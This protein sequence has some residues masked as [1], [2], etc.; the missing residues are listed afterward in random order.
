VYFLFVLVLLATNK[1]VMMKEPKIMAGY[2]TPDSG[3]PL[4]LTV[5]ATTN[6][7]I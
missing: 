7:N 1:E 5:A 2:S 6:K 4:S 3:E